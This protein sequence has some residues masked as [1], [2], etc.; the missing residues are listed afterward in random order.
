MPNTEELRARRAK[1]S[2]TKLALLRQR[3][4]GKATEAAREQRIPKRQAQEDRLPLSFSQQRLWL[5]DQL[6][7]GS[8]FYNVPAAVRLSGSLNIT[9]LERAL[10]EIVR[11]HEALRTTFSSVEGL[12]IQTVSPSLRLELP[13]IDLREH[14]QEER[15]QK[16]EKMARAE[17]QRPFDLSIG[18][19]LRT[20]LLKMGEEDHILLLVMHHIVSDE[21]S[22]SV[23]IR[24]M[25]ALYEAYLTGEDSPLPDLPIQYADYAV[26]QREYLKGE[27]LERQLSYWRERLSGR[28]AVL[29][30]PTDRARPV[31][32]SYRGATLDFQISERLSEALKRA[33]QREGATL[34]MLLLA[35]FKVLLYR[36]TSEEDII[37]GSPIAN[38]T[39]R[40]I[41]GLIGCFINT[42]VLRTKI[43]A[44]ESFRELLERVREETL[45]AY[46]H[47]DIPFERLVEELQPA[48]DL[49]H[50]PLFQVVFVLLNVPMPTL[51]LT[52]VTL[53]PQAINTETSK[54]DMTFF[55]SDKP[56]GL[57][58]VIEYNTDLF[59]E[60]TI[61]RMVGH[62]ERLLDAIVADP[63]QRVSELQMLSADERR[64]LLGDWNDTAQP[65]PAE[66][67]LHQ[68]FEEQVERTPGAVALVYGDDQLSYGELNERAN[69]LAHYLRRNGVVAESL[70]GVLMERSVE[71]VV[72][73]LAILKA[74]GAYVPLDPRYPR[75]RL[76]FMIE[77]ADVALVITQ[78]RLAGEAPQRGVSAVRI[79]ADW[80]QIAEESTENPASIVEA[81]NLAY[82]IYT[83]GSTGRPKGV[84]GLHQGAI[85]RFDW[86]WKTYPFDADEV[87]CQK[88]SLNFLDSLWEIFGPL[89]Q[90]IRVVI[91]PDEEITDP[92][93]FVKTLARQSV[94]RV[95]LVPSLLRVLLNVS[96]NLQEQ[97]PRLKL[98][99]TSGEALPPDLLQGFRELMPH[100]TLLNLYGSSEAS[101]DVTF[102]DTTA[103]S[104]STTSV[105]VGRPI[106][107]TE[108]YVLDSALQ[109]VAL[110]ISGELY[111]GGVP[112][113]RGYHR[114][115]DLTAE[116]FIP[117]PFHERVGERLYRTGD[118]ARYRTDGVIE[119]LGRRDHQVKIRGFR[120][121][122]GEIEAALK[123]HTSVRECVLVARED[124]GE[125]RLIAY[126][127]LKDGLEANSVELRRWL[128]ERLP[129]YMIPA[130]FVTLEKMPLTPSG[131]IDRRALP[132]PDQTR[133]Q[134]EETFV[135]PRTETEK[136]LA[137]IWT[138]VLGV[139][140]IGIHDNFFELGGHSLL[141]TQ[142][143]SRVRDAFQIELSPRQLFETLTVANLST[144][145]DEALAANGTGER[146]EKRDSKIKR[147]SYRDADQLLANLDQ[148]SDEET[149][150]L[151]NAMLSEEG[152]GL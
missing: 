111:V 109:P 70:V 82:V 89:L 138:Q 135:A 84:L 25:A 34:F 46:E 66:K 26:W 47:Q 121:E 137:N 41:E 30:L 83:S 99:V 95:V 13:V 18:P 106:A 11:R 141:A 33:G 145:V 112:L 74:G 85:N 130:V 127:T 36:Y 55:I 71:M 150:E 24:E 1:L 23:L 60:E 5:L 98:W 129:E 152:N 45:E 72:A 14:E 105:P 50:T 56:E 88:T 16:A 44:E 19:L 133:P 124:A 76:E 2:A 114:R 79:D 90:G 32:Q 81:K 73:L 136:A 40:E 20:S 17:A 92:S 58:G 54:F 9:A 100:S 144:I 104:D 87:C 108:V 3:L 4:Q 125:K 142:V 62:Y 94:T 103:H 51:E 15:E 93:S 10:N 43:K 61:R 148:L 107:N 117:N 29:E 49:S 113:A 59:D 69:R 68:M 27:E 6:E 42:L 80:Q 31:V 110:G 75:E 116:Q 63:Q 118:L 67:C 7:S 132:A 101:A 96:E 48:R 120:I 102:H 22:Y 119:L 12:P 65:F 123:E 57:S 115:A 91:I 126:V 8:A 149:D 151:L 122:L 52:G 86:M 53:R 37:V 39:R 146:V 28:L 64:L 147:V 77:D 143:M 139:E 97:I 128:Q 140:R 21:W 78:E 134:P 131:K 38:R 35:A